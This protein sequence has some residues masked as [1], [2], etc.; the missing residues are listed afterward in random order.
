MALALALC[1][2]VIHA[3]CT[4]DTSGVFNLL[5]LDR[6][7]KKKKKLQE[8]FT[9]D[10][11]TS[12]TVRH[13]LTTDTIPNPNPNIN[14][15]LHPTANPNPIPN[16]N[17]IPNANLNHSYVLTGLYPLLGRVLRYQSTCVQYSNTWYNDTHRV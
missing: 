11:T 5:K 7:P 8:P 16:P 6:T 3:L 9:I 17:S 12:E 2:F 13:A 10:T 1:I 15:I 4:A 14:P